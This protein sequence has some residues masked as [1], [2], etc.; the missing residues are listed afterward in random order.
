[1]LEHAGRMLVRT[2]SRSRGAASQRLDAG[3]V[4][5]LVVGGAGGYH[6]PHHRILPHAEVDQHRAVV[7]LVRLFDGGNRLFLGERADT[8]AAVC[9]GQLDEIRHFERRIAVGQCRRTIGTVRFTIEQVGLRVVVLVEQRLPLTDHAVYGV[10]QNRDLHR[11][12]VQERGGQLLRT[13]VGDRYVIEAMR[14]HNAMLGGEQSGHL[15]F[16]EYGTTG[17]GLLAALQILRIMRETGR[18]LSELADRLKLYPQKLLNVSISRKIP[19]EQC[20]KL[21]AVQK[22]IEEKLGSHGRVLLRYSGTENLCRV[23]VEGEDE[24]FVRRAVRRLADAA[25]EDLR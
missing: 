20:E 11:S 4:R 2:G 5:H 8:H 9:L 24:D 13:K 15:I 7:D 22:E 16:R 10:V 14:Q 12:V 23:M 6:R 3:L 17:D 19:F 25:S 21:T 18:P 1:M